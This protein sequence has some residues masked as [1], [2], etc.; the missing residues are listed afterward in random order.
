[1]IQKACISLYCTFYYHMDENLTIRL[2]FPIV[3]L[4]KNRRNGINEKRNHKDVVAK[5]SAALAE[6]I[7]IHFFPPI[8]IYH[9]RVKCG[10][11]WE[12]APILISRWFSDE[13]F[14]NNLV[15]LVNKQW[16]QKTVPRRKIFLRNLLDFKN[17]PNICSVTV[18]WVF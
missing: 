8:S 7:K 16:N 6:D 3:K 18:A 5:S 11:H 1:M 2:I 15:N 4:T 9:E 10:S 14:Q 17:I 13:L 12:P